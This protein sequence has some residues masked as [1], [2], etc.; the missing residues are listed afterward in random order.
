ME[1]DS[2]PGSKTVQSYEHRGN[3]TLVK[4]VFEKEGDIVIMQVF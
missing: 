4:E 1:V 3:Q 2:I